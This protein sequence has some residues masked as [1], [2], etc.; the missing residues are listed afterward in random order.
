MRILRRFFV[1]VF[2]LAL[3]W[4]ASTASAQH[5]DISPVNLA[6]TIVTNGYD[7]STGDNL[8]N[9][10]VFGLDFGEDPF[11]PFFIGDPGFNSPAGSGLLG[12]TPL[13]FDILGQLSGAGPLPFN[14][15]YWD[16]TGPVTW[17][18]VPDGETLLLQFGAQNVEVGDGTGLL[19][20]FN[21]GTPFGDGSLH[22]HLN[23][24]LQDETGDSLLGAS[25]TDGIYAISMQLR[26]AGLTTSDPFWLVFNLNMSEETHEIAMESF[27]AV[28]E[29]GSLALL[30]TG[31]VGGLY[32]RK[33]RQA[34]QEADGKLPETPTSPI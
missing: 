30:M 5:V 29:P 11:D 1:R 32:W 17:G 31:L 24:F 23:T 18:A 22:R 33:R 6:G 19:P 16:G 3:L 34:A 9:L 2:P 28:P 21:L 12:G 25:V 4:I 26:Q 13:G 8:L 14:L 20:G 7:D 10:R 15:S 27:T